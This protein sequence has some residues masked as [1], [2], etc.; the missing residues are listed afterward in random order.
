MSRSSSPTPV[1]PAATA[2]PSV[3]L[4][5]VGVQYRLLTERQTTLKGRI[6]GLFSAVPPAGSEFWALR[7]LSLQ[8]GR[9]EIVGVIGSNGSGKSTLLRV[10]AGILPQTTGQARTEGVLSPLLDLGSTLN[11]NLTGRQN[12]QL[13]AAMNR[14]PAAETASFIE[15][16]ADYSELGSFF[17]VPVRMY[18]SGMMARLSFAL[19][20][21][22]SPDVLLIDEVLAVGD[23]NFQRKSYF[24]MMKLIE[25]GGLAMI[26]SH[27]LAFVEQVCTR[28]IALSGGN[29]YADGK[30]ASVVAEYRRR[31][32]TL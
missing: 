13:F 3:H 29:L 5:D 1:K 14:I 24:R 19:A 18:S 16:A 21:Q 2:A 27:N 7:N 11:G 17:E 6:L 12:A 32:G 26:V 8:V 22:V 28:A 4:E 30:P 25:R 10:V 9:G 20:T 31:A 23:E 15:K